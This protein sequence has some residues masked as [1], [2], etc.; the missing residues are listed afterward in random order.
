LGLNRLGGGGRYLL[1]GGGAWRVRGKGDTGQEG[2]RFG[3]RGEGNR[4]RGGES[5]G[6]GKGDILP[7][8]GGR[9]GKKKNRFEN[10]RWGGGG[11][12]GACPE[13]DPVS[14]VTWGGRTDCEK[15]G[16]SMKGGGGRSS[17]GTISKGFPGETEQPMEKGGGEAGKGMPVFFD[18]PC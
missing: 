14:C 8:E 5:K 18:S 10:W 13:R 16:G 2:E 3:Q 17:G 15:K 9:C 7:F 4:V 12:D 11:G 1:M 6:G